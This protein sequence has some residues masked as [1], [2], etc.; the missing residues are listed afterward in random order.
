MVNFKAAE[1]VTNFNYLGNDISYKNN[2]NI[3]NKLKVQRICE[4]ISGYLKNKALNEK[5]MKFYKAMASPILTYGNETCT[6]TKRQ[7]K[8]LNDVQ[9]GTFLELRILKRIENYI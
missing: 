5:Q 6:T 1:Q 3:D 7:T 2:K 8:L 4:K 9:I